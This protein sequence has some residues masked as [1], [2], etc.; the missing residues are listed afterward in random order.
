[1]T[2]RCC[3][4]NLRRYV[5]LSYTPATGQ[6]DGRGEPHP[7]S[8]QQGH[9][10]PLKLHHWLSQ[11]SSLVTGVQCLHRSRGSTMGG[12]LTFLTL[13]SSAHCC[14]LLFSKIR[15]REA[16]VTFLPTPIG[17]HWR[18]SWRS[19]V[20]CNWSRVFERSTRFNEGEAQNYCPISMHAA[21]PTQP[22]VP[23]H[24]WLIFGKRTKKTHSWPSG[25]RESSPLFY[26]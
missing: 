26:G 15:Q 14:L 21:D 2:C 12:R 4:N 5:T 19:Q 8:H 3:V 6:H 18:V 23:I 17:P 20:R 22:W 16:T 11:S 24:S 9:L 13:L 10:P 25:S 7:N 1:M